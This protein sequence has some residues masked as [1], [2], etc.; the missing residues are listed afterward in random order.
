MHKQRVVTYSQYHHAKN[1]SW[2][3]LTHDYKEK[4]IVISM[5]D[6]LCKNSG[7]ESLASRIKTFCIFSAMQEFVFARHCTAVLSCQLFWIVFLL[8]SGIFMVLDVE[9]VNKFC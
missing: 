2:N 9:T 4:D 1:V 8:T 6:I 5:F 3:I 7:D